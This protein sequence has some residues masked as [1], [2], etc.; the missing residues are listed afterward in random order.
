VDKLSEKVQ[1]AMLNTTLLGRFAEPEEMAKVTL[2]LA[3]ED[4]SF[5]TGQV[6]IADGGRY[7]KL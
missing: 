3:S 6:I 1:Q 5:I 7:D 2:F 4:S